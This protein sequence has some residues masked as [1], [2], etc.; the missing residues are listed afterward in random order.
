M[1]RA[2]CYC[3][4]LAY[5]HRYRRADGVVRN[6]SVVDMIAC[7]HV[8]VQMFEGSC[9][10]LSVI[11][12]DE[13]HLRVLN[14]ILEKMNNGLDFRLPQRRSADGQYYRNIYETLTLNEVSI[15]FPFQVQTRT[16]IKIVRGNFP[17]HQLR[18]RKILS[19]HG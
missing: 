14:H 8:A 15:A 19:Q 12:F 18:W 6:L 13:W 17:G 9:F 5:R 1:T 2:Y 3:R 11:L 4:V 16:R 10:C 7:V